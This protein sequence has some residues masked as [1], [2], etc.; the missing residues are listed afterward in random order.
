[1]NAVACVAKGACV[2]GGFA[3][4][5]VGIGAVMSM[6]CVAKRS[7]GVRIASFLIIT[8]SHATNLVVIKNAPLP[9]EVGGD[10]DAPA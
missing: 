4:T 3:V 2:G 1:M 6:T 9:A 5:A 8:A 10:E 7:P